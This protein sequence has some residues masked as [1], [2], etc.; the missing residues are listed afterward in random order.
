MKATHPI[1]QI[2][3]M[4]RA[5][6]SQAI[7][8]AAQFLRYRILR[9]QPPRGY[10]AD[11]HANVFTQ[12]QHSAVH[13][14]VDPPLD[15]LRIAMVSW[16]LL[17]GLWS[18]PALGATLVYRHNGLPAVEVGL[19]LLLLLESRRGRTRPLRDYP[20]LWPCLAVLALCT[21]AAIMRIFTQ[22]ESFNWLRLW[23]HGEPMVRGALL[24]VAIAGH[25][26][27]ARIAWLSLLAGIS[28]L[29]VACL[30]QHATGISRW[31]NDLELGWADGFHLSP[32]PRA[33]GLT[34]YTNLTAAI[35]ATALPLLLLPPLLR[36]PAN[37]LLRLGLALGGVAT[38]FALCYTNS[39]G[40]AASAAFVACFFLWRLS[41]RWGFCGLLGLSLL[42]LFFWPGSLL[43]I[44][45]AFLAGFTLV[46]TAGWRRWR[47]A[48]AIT[49]GLLFAGGLLVI[50]GY[51]L[52]Y[53]LHLRLMHQGLSDRAR[54]TLAVQ[55]LPIIASAPCWGVGDA[56]LESRLL[57]Q[58]DSIIAPLPHNQRN[59]HNQYLQWADA[60]GVPVALAFTALV[61]WCVCWLLRQ[62]PKWSAPFQQTIGLAAA[63][64]LSIFLVS[65][66][67][68]AFFWRIEGGGFFWS[69]V[70]VAAAIGNTAITP[71]MLTPPRQHTAS[72]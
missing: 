69:I 22:G 49:L 28:L 12:E 23:Q 46:G 3:L 50:N 16:L 19:A 38:V 56:E 54:S 35:L 57:Q 40:P 64:G 34:S 61:W 68:D 10:R 27:W 67:A 1:L 15:C 8:G 52:K 71:T 44:L 32:G 58:K 65:N 47:Y 25:P 39:R 66:L 45:L 59:A 4:L 62:A 36:V 31:Y 43:W 29:V 70:A 5:I 13:S 2:L 41:P 20:F 33:Q 42:L 37:L 18:G 51:V 24:Y 72:R 63:V 14:V 6:I 21:L 17:V 9:K 30:I 53:P 60:E 7:F 11:Y 26:R 48:Q 55:S